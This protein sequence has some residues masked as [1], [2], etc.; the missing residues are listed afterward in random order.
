M[1]EIADYES[2]KAWFERKPSEI[3]VAMAARAALR[4]VPIFDWS[5]EGNAQERRAALILP[6]LRAMAVASLAGRLPRQATGVLEAAYAAHADA[7]NATTDVAN[8]A[9]YAA[10][11]AAAD[12]AYA[13][14]YA[15]YAAADAA[16]SANADVAANAA[17]WEALT[18]DAE[19]VEPDLET[20]NSAKALAGELSTRRLWPHGTPDWAAEGTDKLARHLTE[21][22]ELWDYWIDWYRRVVDGEPRNEDLELAI[23]LI[24]NEDWRHDDNPLHVNRIIRGLVEKHA[25]RPS[26]D[27]KALAAKFPSADLLEVDLKTAQ[28]RM[29][30]VEVSGDELYQQICDRA[31]YGLGTFSSVELSN[32][33]AAARQL[34]ETLDDVLR[35]QRENPL[36]VHAR[37][38][39]VQIE[40]ARLIDVDELP[41]ND[42]KLTTLQRDLAQAHP[43]IEDAVPTVREFVEARAK[44][45]MQ[46]PDQDI[47][48]EAKVTADLVLATSDEGVR[49]LGQPGRE[50][51][52]HTEPNAPIDDGPTK[53]AIYSLGYILF[54]APPLQRYTA[55]VVA[56]AASLT[57]LHQALIA[58]E[59][60]YLK[61]LNFF[62]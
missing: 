2:A 32:Q 56:G 19:W 59:A 45:R 6:S 60:F 3:C 57:A 30:P 31:L 61:L 50:A 42:F 46:A 53:D 24:P 49:M 5:L 21:A 13:D 23:C 44:E 39:D 52:D 48:E 41:K 20:G 51:L 1:V 26:E 28:I 27:A 29:A 9:A 43:G 58:A 47:L 8:A 36:L 11:A 7:A 18:R 55:R 40:L 16:R 33:Y 15:A 10:R 17:V 4:I 12:A 25:P 62:Y 34:V 37:V 54:R 14:A 35:H 38:V 22:G